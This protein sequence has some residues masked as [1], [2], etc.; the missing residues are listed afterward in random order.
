MQHTI[1]HRQGKQKFVKHLPELRLVVKHLPELPAVGF[2]GCLGILGLIENVDS[3]LAGLR[4]KL[5]VLRHELFND[6]QFITTND[7]IGLGHL[8]EHGENGGKKYG[9]PPLLVGEAAPPRLL[10]VDQRMA[11]RRP[12]NGTERSAQHHADSASEY[13]TDPCHI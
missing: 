13:F 5:Q 11:N 7:P 3:K 8:A 1:G 12:E 6:F 9:L 4:V 2:K 10:L